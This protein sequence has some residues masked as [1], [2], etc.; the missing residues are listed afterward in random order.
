MLRHWLFI[1]FLLILYYLFLFISL[2]ARIKIERQLQVSKEL[3][4]NKRSKNEIDVSLDYE[5][6]NR[7]KKLKYVF[8]PLQIT[9]ENTH[10]IIYNR[11]HSDNSVNV[12]SEK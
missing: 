6:H 12:H 5:E 4:A 3:K 1:L 9:P 10:Y 7:T 11:Q 8:F 2:A